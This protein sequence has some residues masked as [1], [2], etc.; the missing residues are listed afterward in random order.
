[1]GPASVIHTSREYLTPIGPK[2]TNHLIPN[3]QAGQSDSSGAQ[4]AR[5]KTFS[6]CAIHQGRV[7]GSSIPSLKVEKTEE[8]GKSAPEKIENRPKRLKI[9][10]KWK[11]KPQRIRTLARS[12]TF[13]RTVGSPFG[14][15]CPS[16]RLHDPCWPAGN[17][18]PR[19]VYF[20]KFLILQVPS[21]SRRRRL[22]PLPP[23]YYLAEAVTSTDC[24]YIPCLV[25]FRAFLM[26]Q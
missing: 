24:S 8:T 4:L 22:P 26:L 15:A 2:E 20:F 13:E 10:Q 14:G 5:F 18:R 23:M 25:V 3:T 17:N 1:M 6:G 9:V 11:N 7:F 12:I 19:A 16:E 21:L